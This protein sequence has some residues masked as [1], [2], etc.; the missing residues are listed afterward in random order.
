[1]NKPFMVVPLSEMCANKLGKR[2]IGDYD[3]CVVCGESFAN[4]A[5]GEL[6]GH[7]CI[8]NPYKTDDAWWYYAHT[9]HNQIVRDIYLVNKIIFA[10]DFMR[11][12]IP[13]TKKCAVVILNK[14]RENYFNNRSQE[15]RGELL[16]KFFNFIAEEKRV[17][18]VVNGEDREYVISHIENDTIEDIKEDVLEKTFNTSRRYK[19]W[20]LC[21]ENGTVL[22]DKAQISSFGFKENEKLI[23]S[24]KFA[25][26][27]NMVPKGENIFIS[28]PHPAHL[29]KNGDF[30]PKEVWDGAMKEWQSKQQFVNEY[31]C[32]PVISNISMSAHLLSNE[33]IRDS[34]KKARDADKSCCLTGDHKVFTKDGFKKI[35]DLVSFVTEPADKLFDKIH[36]GICVACGDYSRPLI[37]VY[38]KYICG[39]CN[40]LVSYVD[41]QLS[42]E[43]IFC[44]LKN[45]M[46]YVIG[47]S[48]GESIT[49]KFRLRKK[50]LDKILF[51]IDTEELFDKLEKHDVWA[52]FGLENDIV[53]KRNAIVEVLK[54]IEKHHDFVDQGGRSL[55]AELF[56]IIMKMKANREFNPDGTLKMEDEEYIKTIQSTQEKGYFERTKDRKDPVSFYN[57]IA[58]NPD[59]CIICDMA[60]NKE[61]KIVETPYGFKIAC[62]IH[63]NHLKYIDVNAIGAGSVGKD[64]WEKGQII[65]TAAHYKFEHEFE[66]WTKRQE[67]NKEIVEKKEYR[68]KK[69]TNEIRMLGTGDMR[70]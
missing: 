12:K 45:S 18:I 10:D 47:Y 51:N 25:G 13:D 5:I 36:G 46:S 27:D 11:S 19:D 49:D 57:D 26:G 70:K 56:D 22:D 38:N 64:D 42:T 16:Q 61:K 67:N 58:D 63:E 32:V 40:D 44:E 4:S 39:D 23:L 9:K 35:S 66:Q 53:F 15:L 30:I 2:T 50:W 59:A 60:C 29:N 20:E 41:G 14:A 34:Y 55:Q 52:H 17:I 37:K 62:R 43:R 21:R 6:A 7:Y 8:Q 48:G 65:L 1:M 31:S 3:H 28:T 69:S 68:V 24:L 33:E 54:K